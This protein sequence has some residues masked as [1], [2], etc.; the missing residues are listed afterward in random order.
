MYKRS[1]GFL[2]SCALLY[3]A[4]SYWQNKCNSDRLETLRQKLEIEARYRQR[5]RVVFARK[6]VE[7]GILITD[8]FV[9]ERE[10]PVNLI[11]GQAAMHTS[12]VVGRKARFAVQKGTIVSNYDLDP[13]PP[14]LS[15]MAVQ[16]KMLIRRGTPIND[17]AVELIQSTSE[18]LPT[19]HFE[20]ISEVLGRLAKRDIVS[21]QI[22]DRDQV[23][24]RRFETGKPANDN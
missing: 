23:L 9:E 24:P 19:S 1:L 22:L 5:G 16:S 12:D 8:D 11:P 15:V 4:L 18:K 13:Y 3:T 10:L 17:D 2:L 7:A 6:N 14:F 20:K 21:G